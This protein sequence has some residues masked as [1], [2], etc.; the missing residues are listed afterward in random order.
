MPMIS[1]SKPAPQSLPAWMIALSPTELID[2]AIWLQNDAQ[3]LY[4]MARVHRDTGNKFCAAQVQDNAAHS[5]SL[6]RA[7]LG[8]A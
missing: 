4:R 8:S 1:T 6:A 3:Y 5:A 7:A 2:A